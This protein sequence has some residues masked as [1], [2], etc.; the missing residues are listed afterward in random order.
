MSKLLEYRRMA[1]RLRT[2]KVSK[3]QTLRLFDLSWNG[4]DDLGIRALVGGLETNTTLEELNLSRNNISDSGFLELVKVLEKCRLQKLDI[5]RNRCFGL[6]KALEM[7][8]RLLQDEKT[9]LKIVNTGN[10]LILKHN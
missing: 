5:S 8:L 1:T 9:E 10:T 3:H 4:I 2:A 6:N 7:L